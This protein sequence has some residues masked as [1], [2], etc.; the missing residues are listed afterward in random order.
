MRMDAKRGAEVNIRANAKTA[1]V[2]GFVRVEM[3]TDSSDDAIAEA[4][5]AEVCKLPAMALDAIAEMRDDP[6]PF[7]T[8]G[9]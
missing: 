4:F 7:E 6:C 3:P 1:H 2:F 5:F 9:E 8:N